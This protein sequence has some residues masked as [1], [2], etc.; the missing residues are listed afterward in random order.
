[1]NGEILWMIP[2]DDIPDVDAASFDPAQID[3]A[4]RP[5]YFDTA[6]ASVLSYPTSSTAVI[7]E[8]LNKF[9]S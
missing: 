1:V 6:Q 3:A 7:V 8:V 5:F 2:N 4:F 9:A